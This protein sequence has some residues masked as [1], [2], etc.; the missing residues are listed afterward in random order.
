[1][2]RILKRSDR[3]L[4]IDGK[5]FINYLKVINALASLYGS[6]ILLARDKY[7]WKALR[8][9]LISREKYGMEIVITR[10]RELGKRKKVRTIIII[11]RRQIDR[12]INHVTI[13]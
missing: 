5:R 10:Y 11:L 3:V 8:L 4:F 7:I 2:G 1:M 6:V 13:G 9:A 12:D